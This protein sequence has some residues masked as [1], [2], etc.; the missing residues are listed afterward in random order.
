MATLSD[1]LT[2]PPVADNAPQIV[3]AQNQDL[4]YAAEALFND[5][6][7]KMKTEL[8]LSQINA[9]TRGHLFA[10]QFGSSLMEQLCQTMETMMISKG[11]QGRKELTEITRNIHGENTAKEPGLLGH[12]MGV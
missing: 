8:T 1:Q 2:R 10:S 11:R 4:Q 7:L 12:L 3:Q 9:L 6:N 5:D